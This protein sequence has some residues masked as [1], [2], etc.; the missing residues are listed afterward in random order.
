MDCWHQDWPC[1]L[2]N[3]Q[4]IITAVLENI[5]RTQDTVILTDALA[6][7][8]QYDKKYDKTLSIYLQLKQGPVFELI[9]KHD[10]YD[11]IQNKVPIHVLDYLLDE[12]ESHFAFAA[13]QVLYLMKFDRDK[14]IQLLINNTDRIPIAT[15][16]NQLKD[17]PLLQHLYLDALFKKD[18]QCTHDV[19]ATTA[20]APS[21][22]R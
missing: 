10:L 13:L 15:V 2:Y 17:E 7:L 9:E 3:I 8:Y 20:R 5:R 22:T 14:A 6:L 11:S 21:L 1:T 12:V 18:S 16:L 4:N 19:G